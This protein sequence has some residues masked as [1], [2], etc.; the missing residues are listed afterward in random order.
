MPKVVRF[1]KNYGLFRVVGEG[2][3]RFERRFGRQ[4]RSFCRPFGTFRA[5][6]TAFWTAAPFVL[7]FIWHFSGCLNGVLDGG[8]VRFAVK[9]LPIFKIQAKI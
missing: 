7:P 9:M 5:V 6:W 3:G 1:H 2:Y 8:A 4:R